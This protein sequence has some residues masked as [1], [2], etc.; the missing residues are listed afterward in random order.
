MSGVL[1]VLIVFSFIFLVTKMGLEHNK[2]KERL[3]ASAYS[4]ASITTSELRAM[5]K[6]AVAEA[7]VPLE[8]RFE[9]IERRIEHLDRPRLG[10]GGRSPA[11]EP[12]A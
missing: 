9:E 11:D 4:D 2:Q 5:I 8:E 3:P 7:Q 6:G 12:A 10:S 1:I